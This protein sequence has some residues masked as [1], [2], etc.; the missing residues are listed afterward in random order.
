VVA[1]RAHGRPMTSEPPGEV[2]ALNG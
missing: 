2:N 1:I